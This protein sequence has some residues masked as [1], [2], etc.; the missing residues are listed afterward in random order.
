MSKPSIPGIRNVTPELMA[1]LKP[2]KENI[3]ILSGRRGVKLTE[4][5]SNASTSDIIKKINLIVKRLED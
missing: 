5:N 4:L 1:V 3:E 2:L